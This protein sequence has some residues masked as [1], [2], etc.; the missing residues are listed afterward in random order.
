MFFKPNTPAAAPAGKT[1]IGFNW[2]GGKEVEGDLPS[3]E[4]RSPVDSRDAVGIFPEC[5]ER[6]VER[7]A[8]AA[9][10]AF[11]TWFQVPAPVRGDLIRRM[12]DVLA[13]NKERLAR[14][15][16]REVGKTM[17]E[18]MGEVQEAIDTCVFFASE[19]RRLYGQTVPSEMPHK[20]LSTHRRPVGVCAV[21]TASNFPLAV[22]SWKIIPAILCGNTVVWKPSED[23]PT[24][25]YLFARCMMDAGLPAG[26]VNVVN[27]R[28]PGGVGQHLIAGI[29]KGFFQKVSFTGST[30]VGRVIGEACGR[31]LISPALELGGKNPMIVMEDADLDNAVQSALFGAFGTAGQRCTSLANL[32][33]H[34]PIAEAFKARFL[35]AVG[36]AVLGNPLQHPEVLYGPMIN[37]R[38]ARL[39]CGGARWTDENRDD[40]VLGHIAH[41][42]Y[43]QP[44]IWEGVTP[45]MKLFHTEV[46]GPTVNLCIADDFDQA[47][48]LANGTPYGLSSAIYTENRAWVE[49]FKAGIRAGMASINNSTVGAEAH[50]PFGGLGWSGNG[51]REGG[52]W[53]LDSY[54]Q[55]QAVNDDASG[56]LQL[57]QID[58]DYAL[59]AT[60][61]RTHWDQL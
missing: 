23:A 12:G 2:I 4:S 28:G 37:A 36:K 25:A 30:A 29:D 34:K 3:F 22:P 46:F 51:S 14:V 6:D 31:N 16:T 27:G 44:C 7:A 49:R 19:G 53:A 20:T 38:H 58:T 33:L 24:I 32:I 5:G 41:G 61:D 52:V 39:L 56:H 10:Q 8:K 18:A 48:A 9:S 17:R 60:Y 43:M 50:L 57:A 11:K 42:A 54:T 47:L 35:E 21:M 26:V 55:W 59:K 45:E 15:L 40:R 1:L 13:Q